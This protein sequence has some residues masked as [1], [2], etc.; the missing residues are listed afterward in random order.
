MSALC[1]KRTFAGNFGNS[2]VPIDHWSQ[3]SARREKSGDCD[4]PQKMSGGLNAVQT[5]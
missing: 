2:Y 3:L 5:N 1:K 4:A